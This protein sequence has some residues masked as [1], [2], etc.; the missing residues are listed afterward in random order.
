[1]DDLKRKSTEEEAGG[2]AEK[3]KGK[4]KEGAGKLFGREDWEAEGEAE[5]VEGGIREEGGRAGRKISDAAE[6]TKEKLTG[7]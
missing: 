1:M 2:M 4:V 6:K 7:E 3:A 5:Q